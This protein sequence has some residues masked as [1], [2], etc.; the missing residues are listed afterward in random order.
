MVDPM[1]ASLC[2]NHF[3][4]LILLVVSHDILD[5]MQKYGHDEVSGDTNRISQEC[6]T[7]DEAFDMTVRSLYVTAYIYIAAQYEACSVNL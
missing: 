1:L 4:V 7:C 2:R 5:D 3:S 6:T